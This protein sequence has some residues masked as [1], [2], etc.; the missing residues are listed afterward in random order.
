VKAL[1]AEKSEPTP[2]EEEGTNWVLWGVLAAVLIGGFV[3]IGKKIS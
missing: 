3:L 2:E 1:T